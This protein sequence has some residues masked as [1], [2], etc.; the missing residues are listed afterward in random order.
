MKNNF[1]KYLVTFL[2][3]LGLILDATTD[4]MVEL[5]YSLDAPEWVGII[6]R[7]IMVSLGVVKVAPELKKLKTRLNKQK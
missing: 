6:F 2:Y 5:L 4:L 1:L 7:I 3:F